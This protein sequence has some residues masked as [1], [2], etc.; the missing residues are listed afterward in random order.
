MTEFLLVGGAVID[1]LLGLEPK[2]K[3][4]LAVGYSEGEML[5]LGFKRVGKDFPVFLH[6]ETREEYAIPRRERST[7][8]KYQDFVFETDNVSVEE[9]LARRDLT[10][11]AMALKSDGTIVDPYNGQKDLKNGILRHTT[12]AF[13]EDPLR[14]LRIARFTAR[15]NG[16]KIAEET[17]AFIKEMKPMLSSLSKERVF[18]EM[19]KAMSE[20]EPHQFFITLLEL[21][22]LDIV[23]PSIYEWT[24]VE[25]NNK[26]HMEGSLFNH[27]ML[28]LK[29]VSELTEDINTRF[30]A[31]FHDIAKAKSFKE[32]GNFYSHTNKNLVE[33]E[34]NL[35]KKIL[36]I[37]KKMSTAIRQVAIFHHKIHSFMELKATTIV[38]MFQ[39]K[40]FPKN[41]E[42]LNILLTASQA[43]SWG[44]WILEEGDENRTLDIYETIYYSDFNHFEKGE[45]A[46]KSKYK[47]GRLK[48]GINKDKITKAFEAFKKQS[49]K[50]LKGE[51]VEKI[52][53]TLYLRR[54]SAVKKTLK[55][56]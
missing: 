19:E 29:M 33:E 26:A 54:V 45:R 32:F 11:N 50:D 3:D 9:D 17:K 43:D 30:A 4:Y 1:K 13:K 14:V 40:S 48:R 25:H 24:K 47:L 6:P 15:Y 21:N 16:F 2:D 20:K 55:E 10:I 34:L 44:R 36:R 27:A 53:E 49:V 18:K 23:F 7:G 31:L 41:I 22:V 39:D 35:L 42:E 8:L 56:G 37:S 12:E 38:K 28:V 46:Y 51:S 5:S 52:K